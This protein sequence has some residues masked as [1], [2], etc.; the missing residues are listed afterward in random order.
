MVCCV[1]LTP[2]SL[3]GRRAATELIDEFHPSKGLED[4]S[5]RVGPSQGTSRHAEL[6]DVDA[7]TEN[8]A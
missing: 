3:Q 5:G 2:R 8:E 1:Y 6:L 7:E 4:N